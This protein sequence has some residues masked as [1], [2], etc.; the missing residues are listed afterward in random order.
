MPLFLS[1]AATEATRVDLAGRCPGR[2]A[3]NFTGAYRA[4]AEI[5]STFDP[6]ARNVAHA[7]MPIVS[8]ESYP[9]SMVLPHDD[10][11]FRSAVVA[12]RTNGVAHLSVVSRAGVDGVF[13]PDWFASEFHIVPG[14]RLNL[15]A[16][17][18]GAMPVTVL[19]AYRD[20]SSGSAAAYWCAL[21][22]AFE[23]NQFGDHRPP[24][25]IFDD[26]GAATNRALLANGHTTWELPMVGTPTASTTAAYVRG[27]A[28]LRAAGARIGSDFNVSV[29][30]ARVVT[31][32]DFVIHRASEIRAFTAASIAAVRWSG[33]LVGIALVVAAA[34][35][36]ARRNRREY[37]IRTLRGARPSAL[38]A[39]T[40]ARLM[41]AVVVGGAVGVLAT[42]ALVRAFGPSADLNSAARLDG[43]RFGGIAVVVALGLVGLT[44]GITSRA[45]DRRLVTRPAVVRR[46][47]F[48]LAAAA[49]CFVAFRHLV[50]HGG[51]ALAGADVS[52]V[53]PWAVLF[54]LLL[55]WTVLLV[56]ARPLLA[57]L[58][59]FRALGGGRSPAVMLGVRR[60]VT[61]PAVGMVTTGA[62]ALCLATFVYASTLSASINTSL[63][64]KA[65]MFVGADQRIAL[66]NNPRPSDVP[67]RH[68]TIV[69]RTEAS[70]GPN[71]VTLLGVDPATF[72]TVAFWQRSFGS[73]S[74]RR[75]LNDLQAPAGGSLPVLIA[76]TPGMSTTNTLTVEGGPSF[77]VRVVGEP[78]LWPTMQSGDTFVIAPSG[79]L[80]ARHVVGVDELWLKGATAAAGKTANFV[81]NGVIYNL[82]P[83]DVLDFNNTLPVRWSL[84]LLEAVGALAGIAFAAAELAIIDAR[85]RARQLAFLLWHRMGLSVGGNRV[86]CLTELAFPALLGVAAAIAAALTTARV[87]VARFDALGSLPPP[88][89]FVLDP[90]PL[91]VGGIAV[92]AIVVALAGW[93]HRVSRS[94]NAMDLLRVAD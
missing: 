32:L 86:A 67:S 14:Q 27:I 53:D 88:A 60:A 59:R 45:F 47:P 10:G 63:L 33:V 5:L 36:F 9:L 2:V 51:V 28:P 55:V 23:P 16:T 69:T 15:G 87:V 75:Y 26:A 46:L 22:P 18:T 35:L 81:G 82:S 42:G 85:A 17:A 83:S 34:L 90:R 89:Q 38:G 43:A 13:V 48:E 72:A 30:P 79:A 74:L 61:D 56:L 39:Q 37:E 25:L 73:R 44:V 4:R 62:V 1:S 8:D 76:G 92:A 41:P 7:G 70:L 40:A 49:V 31:D 58:R 21:E 93:S 78:R 84:G 20:V 71:R 19:G 11:V 6:L 65:H 80:A 94:G 29:P 66:T 68:G 24:V 54:P 12:H 52:S 50:H 57:V 3:A 91:V 64:A 77:P